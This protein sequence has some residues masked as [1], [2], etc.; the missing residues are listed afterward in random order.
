ML[1]KSHPFISHHPHSSL[2]NGAC[3]TCLII[4]NTLLVSCQALASSSSEEL[5][6]RS[7]LHSRLVSLSR[8]PE[9]GEAVLQP[10]GP[11][12]LLHGECTPS[13]P[14][15]SSQGKKYRE[16][17]EQPGQCWQLCIPVCPCLGWHSW[18]ASC[19][20]ELKPLKISG[21]WSHRHRT[22]G[23][24]RSLWRSS[25]TAPLTGRVT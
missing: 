19:P 11:G 25:R 5:S 21:W 24:G 8:K 18:G 4:R 16:H 1:R 7:L 13:F 12:F 20:R 17:T 9:A 22:V 3:C 14:Q 6:P 10:V 2:I 15:I 23:A